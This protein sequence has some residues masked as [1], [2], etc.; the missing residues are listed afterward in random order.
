MITNT[1]IQCHNANLPKTNVSGAAITRENFQAN[2]SLDTA[3]EMQIAIDRLELP[4]TN[5]KVMPPARFMQPST[6]AINAMIQALQT[7]QATAK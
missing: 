5:V 6:A 3:A 1:C 4:I 7:A 2:L